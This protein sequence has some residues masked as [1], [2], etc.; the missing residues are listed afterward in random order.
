MT[1]VQDHPESSTPPRMHGRPRVL[2]HDKLGLS[3]I[4]IV[5][6]LALGCAFMWW[7]ADQDLRVTRAQTVGLTAERH[8]DDRRPLSELHEPRLERMENDR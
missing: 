4:G 5:L 7:S 8:V 2:R 1:Q 6:T 3:I